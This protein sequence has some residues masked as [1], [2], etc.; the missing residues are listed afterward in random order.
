M[1]YKP[2]DPQAIS[3]AYRTLI[4]AGEEARVW[5]AETCEAL[6]NS[7][8]FRGVLEGIQV[9]VQN[10]LDS[11][12]NK[13]QAGIGAL[14]GAMST[15]FEIGLLVAERATMTRCAQIALSEYGVVC[16]NLSDL[17]EP[18]CRA[19]HTI[20]SQHLLT[21]EDQIKKEFGL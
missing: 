8:A 3:E 7:E 12:L 18:C 20:A 17:D 9:W 15:G 4:H 2:V 5:I 10:R 13:E 16:R 11:G 1:S 21:V 14:G 19:A 6:K